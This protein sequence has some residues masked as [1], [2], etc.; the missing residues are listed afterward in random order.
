MSLNGA[1][2]KHTPEPHFLATDACDM[3]A[4]GGSKGITEINP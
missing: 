4:A 3:P 1:D 2:V